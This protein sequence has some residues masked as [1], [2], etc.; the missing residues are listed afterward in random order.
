[1]VAIVFVAV[2]VV[3]VVLTVVVASALKSSQR[4]VTRETVDVRE[5]S[6]GIS[7]KTT[8]QS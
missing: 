7:G 8:T 6:D 4:D 2:V 5:A 3:V 1:V